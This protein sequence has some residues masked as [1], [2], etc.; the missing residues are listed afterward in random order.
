MRMALMRLII[1]NDFV[2]PGG[3]YRYV[4][5]V[6]EQAGPSHNDSS[7]VIW[8]FH[9]HFVEGKDV[10]TGLIG[11]IIVTARLIDLGN[12]LRASNPAEAER[13]YREAAAIWEDKGAEAQATVAW[14]K[15]GVLCGEQERLEVSLP[16]RASGCDDVASRLGSLANNICEPVSPHEEI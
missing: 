12:G 7:S 3:T 5:R 11:P 1:R 15:L 4:W 13:S 8:M 16:C 10:N 14:V 2:P 9:S 6:P